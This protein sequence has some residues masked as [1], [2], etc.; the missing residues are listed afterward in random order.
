MNPELAQPESQE[1]HARR[2]RTPEEEQE[3]IDDKRAECEADTIC[4]HH[5]ASF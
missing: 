1:M 4:G 2:E 5:W 3:W